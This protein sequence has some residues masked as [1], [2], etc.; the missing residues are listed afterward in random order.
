MGDQS[1]CG[2]LPGERH[3]HVCCRCAGVC[4]YIYLCAYMHTHM[5]LSVGLSLAAPSH[6]PRP[7]SGEVR[8]GIAAVSASAWRPRCRRQAD[9]GRG[10]GVASW[11]PTRHAKTTKS[12]CGPC[13]GRK[14]V[15]HFVWENGHLAFFPYKIVPPQRLLHTLTVVRRIRPQSTSV[16]ICEGEG[17]AT[18]A[19]G[20][21]RVRL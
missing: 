10:A 14:K 5:D 9:R 11:W 4:I 1:A 3:R 13:R 18:A 2:H 15:A 17:G 16:D 12:P 6:R 7:S 21:F 20:A 19:T 8:R